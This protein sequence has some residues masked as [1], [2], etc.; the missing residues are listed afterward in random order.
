VKLNYNNSTYKFK[1]GLLLLVYF[2]DYLNAQN[3][4][5]EA[6]LL[7][8]DHAHAYFYLSFI[9]DKYNN[10]Y[11]KAKE[12]YM[13]SVKFKEDLQNDELDAYFN[14]NGKSRQA[15]EPRLSLKHYFSK[16]NIVFGNMFLLVLIIMFV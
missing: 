3:Y 16:L 2:D 6:I 11:Q 10:N 12:Y 4:L 9:Y 13:M 7:K 8:P 15:D 14:V 1:L 5:K